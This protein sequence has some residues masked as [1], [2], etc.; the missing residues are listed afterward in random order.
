MAV[1][2]IS[3]NMLP[4]FEFPPFNTSIFWSFA[5]TSTGVMVKAAQ[6][7]KLALHNLP[8]QYALTFQGLVT[9]SSMEQQRIFA[10]QNDWIT[11][12]MQTVG[13][14]STFLEMHIGSKSRRSRKRK[15]SQ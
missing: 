9:N 14:L 5:S 12:L 4:I 6:D 10:A 11:E 7:A 13:N 3:Y 8:E 1:L 15:N 2:F